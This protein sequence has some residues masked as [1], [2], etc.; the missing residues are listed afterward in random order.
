[1]HQ[2]DGDSEQLGEEPVLGRKHG[3]PYEEMNSLAA[4]VPAGSG[5]LRIFPYGNGAERTLENRNLGASIH[6]LQFNIHNR[7][8]LARA[9]Q[10]GIVFALNYGAGIMREMGLAVETVRAGHANMFLSPVFAEIFA[11]VIGARVELYSTDGSQGAARGAG[12]GA[13]IYK[14]TEDA[15][16]G[17]ETVRT[18]DPDQYLAR[19]TRKSTPNGWRCWRKISKSLIKCG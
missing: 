15:F 14:N 2:R 4:R 5:G 10:E 7:A 17:L 8:H 18:I 12:I 6:G 19:I 11:A 16:V 13:G 9:T 1:M 3:Q